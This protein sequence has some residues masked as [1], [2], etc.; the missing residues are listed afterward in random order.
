MIHLESEKMSTEQSQRE[1]GYLESQTAV[2][3]DQLALPAVP[4]S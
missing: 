4:S 2:A 1:D 3:E